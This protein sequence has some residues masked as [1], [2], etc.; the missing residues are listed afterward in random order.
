MDSARFPRMQAYLE[1][2]PED[3]ASYPECLVKGDAFAMYRP[4]LLPHVRLPELPRPVAAYLEGQEPE[5]IPDVLGISLAL[6]ARDVAFAD[7]AGF[8]GFVEQ[9]IHELYASPIYRTLMRLLSPTLVVMGAA[10]RW[11][12]FRKGS[13]LRA[14]PAV[15]SEG[16][17]RVELT[18][19]HAPRIY[20]PLV[21][22]TFSVAY[23]V[24]VQ[25]SRAEDARCVL[26]SH[27]DARATFELS[28]K[29]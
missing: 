25:T 20:P 14:V 4:V 12:A 8:L 9:S 27:A 17:R 22:Q 18:L 28:W 15:L 10:A 7:D 29:A 16:R 26:A 19:Q 24:A 2:L 13:E 3:L 11:R 21:L 5:W 23:R 6:L 1:G